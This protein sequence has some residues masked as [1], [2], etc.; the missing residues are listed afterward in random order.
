VGVIL[1][2]ILTDNIPVRA[3]TRIQCLVRS[4]YTETRLPPAL[5]DILA[6][7]PSPAAVSRFRF[8][9]NKGKVHPSYDNTQ[10][11]EEIFSINAW[12]SGLWI[13]TGVGSTAAMSAAGGF[14]MDRSTENLQYMIREHLVDQNQH[15]E[16]GHG[17][18]YPNQMLNIRWN[19][20]YGAV[21]VDGSHMKHD[22]ELGDEIKIDCH[23]PKLQ[24][25]DVKD[26]NSNIR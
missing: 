15:K 4:T 11:L 26:V 7:H 3:R 9:L 14:I 21:Y 8:Q 19:S 13:C 1:P 22:L 18:I 20:Q 17:I 16:L 6:A 23:A 5:N 10:K 25:F 12:S 24:L 2:K